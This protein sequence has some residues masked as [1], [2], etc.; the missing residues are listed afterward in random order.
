V[1][2]RRAKKRRDREAGELDAVTAN[3]GPAP[4]LIPKGWYAD[5]VAPTLLDAKLIKRRVMVYWNVPR[6][7]IGWFPG[8]IVNQCDRDG[9]NYLVKYDRQ[10]T[11]NLFVDGIKATKLSFMGHEAYGV[12]WIC[13]IPEVDP[14]TLLDEDGNERMPMGAGSTLPKTPYSPMPGIGFPGGGATGPLSSPGSLLKSRTMNSLFSSPGAKIEPYFATSRSVHTSPTKGRQSRVGETLE[15]EELCD[16]SRPH[17]GVPL[18][19]TLP[20]IVTSDT[21]F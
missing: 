17:T 20:F 2:S 21:N 7:G 19:V 13:I 14:A 12:Y 6:E 11:K 9:A 10:E 8:T 5:P 4:D 18:S 1:E 16:T 15:M 3:S